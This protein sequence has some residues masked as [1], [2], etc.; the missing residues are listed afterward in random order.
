MKIT[1]VGSVSRWKAGAVSG[2]NGATSVS[3]VC[4]L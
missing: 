1:D 3:T 4:Q 2:F